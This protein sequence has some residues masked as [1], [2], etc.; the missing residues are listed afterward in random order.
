MDID[1]RLEGRPAR[2]YRSK[3]LAGEYSR[4]HSRSFCFL[5]FYGY[6]QFSHLKAVQ[7]ISL[8]LKLLLSCSQKTFLTG[9]LVENEIFV[10]HYS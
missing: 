4:E 9:I 10:S 3:G 1:W 6:L 2:G 8:F 5:R 7:I